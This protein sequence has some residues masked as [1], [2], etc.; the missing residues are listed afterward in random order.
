[1]KV[2][3]LVVDDKANLAQEIAALIAVGTQLETKFASDSA[4]ALRLVEQHPI[5]VAVL[6]Q[7]MEPD[8][9]GTQL[10]ERIRAI[11]PDIRA[12]MLTGEAGADEV[13][14]ALNLGGFRAYLPK[15]RIAELPG[16]VLLQ[17]TQARL[18]ELE[19]R[20]ESESVV[21]WPRPRWPWPW[22][23]G[24]QIS[25]AGRQILDERFVDPGAWTTVLQINAGEERKIARQFS[26]SETLLVEEQSQRT[27]QA[28]I[29]LKTTA[30]TELTA[31]LQSVL[32][33]SWKLSHTIAD[34]VTASTEQ[35]FRLPAEP[36]QSGPVY[37]RARLFQR[38]PVYRKLLVTLSAVCGCCGLSSRIPMIVLQDSGLQATR[39]HDHLSDGSVNVVETGDVS[40]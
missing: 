40:S 11:R 1:M 18:A 5:T 4:N 35:T 14:Q 33:E 22:R 15:G 7:R 27:L 34:S 12:I 23:R 21:L 8:L 28:N 9:S 31:A 3:I 32:N 37:V 6:D 26:R 25:L 13:G 19:Q 29:S 36:D 17:Y 10:F 2:E 24:A 38:A 16:L 39:H 30:L 20:N